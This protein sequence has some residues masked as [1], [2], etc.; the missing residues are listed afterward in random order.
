[1]SLLGLDMGTSA[2]KATIY[3]EHGSIL[4]VSCRE[5]SSYAPAPGWMEMDPSTFWNSAVEVIREAAQK[6][7]VPVKALS[8]SSQGETFIPVD[9]SGVEIHPAIMNTDSRASL[10]VKRFEETIGK[11]RAY[12]IT[13]CVL[14]PMYSLL[15]IM[16][17][18]ENQPDVY[19]KTGKFLS[20]GDYILMKLGGTPYTDYSLACRTMAFDVMNH[21][22]SDDLLNVAGVTS[23]KLPEPVPAGTVAGKMSTS[24]ASM[25]GLSEGVIMAVGGHDQPCGALGA[26]IIEE[27]EVA[28]ST[29]SYE[30]LIASGSK[31][32]LDDAAL[33]YSINSYCHVINDKYVTLA[34]FPAGLVL[35]WFRDQFGQPEVDEAAR[36][37]IDAY[38]LLTKRMPDGPSGICFTPHFIGTGNPYWNPDATGAVLGLTPDSSRYHLFKAIMEGI[39][40]EVGINIE[41]LESMVGEIKAVRTMGGGSKS[42]FWM[43]LRADITSKPVVRMRNS[44]AV[45]LG[46]ALLAGTASGIYSSINE[47]VESSVTS[48]RVFEPNQVVRKQYESQIERYRRFYPTLNDGGLFING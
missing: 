12:G 29:G 28:D 21:R 20:V 30:C 48:A 31:A 35:R 13:G 25:L 16:W 26:G 22:W 27:G 33:S 43:Q 44:E 8:I 2:C 37:G 36:M 39:A 41:V 32:Y 6:A 3:D 11:K 17:L 24:M 42:D 9:E 7:N 23:A 10:Q 40:C 34:F 1:M 38:D 19:N 5:Y 47:A 18:K 15:K 14:H 45:S 4:A 46:A